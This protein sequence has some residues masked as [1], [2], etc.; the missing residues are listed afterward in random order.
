MAKHFQDFFFFNLIGEDL[1]IWSGLTRG[2]GV[3]LAYLVL[4]VCCLFLFVL[5]GMGCSEAGSLQIW[6]MGY[7]NE[8]ERLGGAGLWNP[9]GKG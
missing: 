5:A 6:G 1:G 4:F 7:N 8:Q 3:K 9:H 2:K